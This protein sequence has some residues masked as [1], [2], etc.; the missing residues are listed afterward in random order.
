MKDGKLISLAEAAALLPEEGATLA[1][2]GVTLYRRPMAFALALRQR[3]LREGAPRGLTLLA[4]TA[5]LESDLLIGA[6]LVRRIRSCYVGLEI[7]GLAPHFTAAAASGRIEIVE[8]TEASLAF[9][10]R[11]R[12]A[13]VGFMPSHA[14]QG[15]DL[16]RLRPDVR[17]VSD[18]YSGEELTAFPPIGCDFAVIHALEADPDGNAMIG[19]NRGVDPELALVAEHV[20]VTAD[21]I[22]PRLAKA[23]ILGPTVQAVVDAPGGA[24]PTSCH[25]LYPLDGIAALRYTEAAATEAEASLLSE[26][27]RHHGLA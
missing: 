17:T 15:T 11:A 20:L 7:F 1:L 23:D 18:P 21:R 27:A 10:I 14:W 19:G 5:G 26:W 2:G 13:G 8:E 3:F 6:G 24:W 12:L 16:F 9:G 22:V 25:P 4:F